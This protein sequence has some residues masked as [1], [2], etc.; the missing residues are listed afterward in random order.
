VFEMTIFILLILQKYKG[1]IDIHLRN[2]CLDQN[3]L[4]VILGHLSNFPNVKSLDLSNGSVDTY[5]YD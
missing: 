5:M 1:V 3:I 4:P 2:C